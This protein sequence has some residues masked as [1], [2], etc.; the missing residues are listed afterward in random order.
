LKLRLGI[1]EIEELKPHEEVI[2]AVVARLTQEMKDDGV[3]KDPLIVDQKDHVILDGMHRFNALK[4][5]NCRFAPCCLLDYM[6]PQITVGSWFRTFTV[7]EAKSVAEEIL[8][9]MKLD[10]SLSQVDITGLSVGPGTVIVT[11]GGTGFSLPHSTDLVEQCRKA[12]SIEKRMVNSGH[13][14]TYLSES[15]AIQRLKSG[16]ADF[17]IV[18]PFFTKEAIRK[19]GSDRLLLPHKATRHIIPSRPLEIDVPLSLLTDA[20]ITCQ[21]AD[22]RLREL[23]ERRKIERKPPGSVI[24]GRRYDEELI[25]FSH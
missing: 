8:A 17:V 9:S 6:S 7:K 25:V 12:V 2:E 10:Y 18:L 1:I 13:E 15:L 16:R 3:V 23:L 5:L 21:E 4:R 19:L 11:T 20:E 24:D 14:V 22:H